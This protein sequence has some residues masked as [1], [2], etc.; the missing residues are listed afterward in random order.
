MDCRHTHDDYTVAY[1]CPI[2]VELAPVKA[3]LDKRHPNLPTSRNINSYTLGRIGEHNVVI[4]VMLDI[5]N[6]KAIVV[7]TQLLNDFRSIRFGLLVGI[8]GSIP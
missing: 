1:I 2:G 4:A 7:A 3:V 8:G 6:N 5:G